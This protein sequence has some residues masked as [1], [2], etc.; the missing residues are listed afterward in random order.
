MFVT[1]LTCLSPYWLWTVP[2]KFVATNHLSLSISW[3]EIPTSRLEQWRDRLSVL[4]LKTRKKKEFSS[5]LGRCVAA[6]RKPPP[7]Q[8]SSGI[9]GHKRCSWPS[10]N[11]LSLHDGKLLL[12]QKSHSNM[13]SL[14]PSQDLSKVVT[15]FCF[16]YNMYCNVQLKDH[17]FSKMKQQSRNATSNL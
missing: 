15:C 5:H 11:H 16:E 3:S 2:L 1:N 17:S 8:P 13:L 9:W 14:I 6:G 10:Y 4:W 12:G 7:S